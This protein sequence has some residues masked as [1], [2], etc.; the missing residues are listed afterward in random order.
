MLLNSPVTITFLP[1]YFVFA[2]RAFSS[3]SSINV[4]AVTSMA[5]SSAVTSVDD[6]LD[7]ESL[8]PPPETA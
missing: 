6:L 5:G 4:F 3:R 7:S 1:S 8:P 2:D